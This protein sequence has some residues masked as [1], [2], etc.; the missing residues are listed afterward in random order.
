MAMLDLHNT[1]QDWYASL[2]E[3]ITTTDGTHIYLADPGSTGL[4]V[5]C[6][7]NIDSE[8]FRVTAVDTDNPSAGVDRLTVERGAGNSVGA[9]H[10]V[11][12]P[13][14][15]L[16]NSLLFEEIHRVLYALKTFVKD[17]TGQQDGIQRGGD[18]SQL[19]VT[20]SD[21]P[22]M[23]VQVAPGSAVVSGEIVAITEATS[24]D[25]ILAPTAPNSRIDLIQIDQYG[26]ISVVTG[27][28]SETPEAPS[29][30]TDCLSLATVEIG[31]G[32]TTIEDADI[33]DT[34]R[35]L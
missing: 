11:T 10:L 30:S 12:A 21:T 19:E 6:W 4:T 18:G 22:D 31:P 26:D 3:A 28:P 25:T 15:L 35:Y 16:N 13:V 20:E 8:I 27:T 23:R 33:T 32:E 2:A 1:S 24:T 17:A 9:T 14:E 7:I 5:P 34:R 29:A